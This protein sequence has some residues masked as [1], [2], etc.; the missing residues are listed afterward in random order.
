MPTFLKK[1]KI[2]HRIYLLSGIS[3]LFLLII[4][5]TGV[6]KMTVIGHELEEIAERDIP[7][8]E[9]L[10]KITVHQLEQAI[11][12]EQ[13]LRYSGV[14]AHDEAHTIESTVKH[15]KKLAHK[16]DEEI[17]QAEK[18][19]E[20]FIKESRDPA[21]IKE[22][23][24]VLEQLKTIE[25]HHKSYE[26]HAFAIFKRIGVGKS[27]HGSVAEA[28]HN[29]ATPGH[30]GG[31]AKAGPGGGKSLAAA[32][33]EVEGEQ[34]QLDKEIAALLHEME[35]F[36]AKSMN[37]ALADEQRGKWLILIMSGVI[38][39]MASVFS[40]LLGRTISKPVS[41]MTASIQEIADGNL[42]ADVPVSSFDDE[43]HEMSQAVEVFRQ[44]LKRV[45]QL[46]ADATVEREKRQHRQNELNQLTGIFGSTIG[47]VFNKISA[48][49]NLMVER[50]GS[51]SDQSGQ[52]KEMAQNVATE[53][54]ESS[55]NAQ[56]LSS[57]TEEM[58]ASVQEISNQVQ[59]SSEVA[60]KA[61]QSAEA[62]KKEVEALQ[63]IANEIG[64]VV[65]LITEIA[66]KTNLLALN[67]TIE[68][69][70]AGEAGKGFA[71]VASE[72][73][74]LA[75]QTSKA[76]EEIGDKITG[77]Q[78]ASRNSAVS[79]QEITKVIQEVD[80]FI[81]AIVAAAEQ[82]DA[83]TQEMARNVAFVADSATRVSENVNHISVQA[84]NVGQ[85]SQEVNGSAT[86]MAEDAGVLS[87]E[88]KTFL[89]A[90]QNT[91]VD[92]DTFESKNVNLQASGQINGSSWSGTVSEISAAHA[93][94]SPAMNYEPGEMVSLQI[95][96]IGSAL[97]A[98]IAIS[99]NGTTTLQ[100]P[101]DLSHLSHMRGE[102]QKVA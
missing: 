21:A 34:A 31:T 80:Q 66:E 99:E 52:T 38:L 91:D 2:G 64:Q 28:K 97:N 5:G 86:S 85:S 101:L 87:T 54:E 51:M 26:E 37:K 22:F 63:G 92:E 70:R 17:I 62:S 95:D 81:S 24:H 84:E 68:A 12:L 27:G 102:L 16:S 65:E 69:A 49:S 7:L 1:L 89:D 42:D 88:V 14:T 15:F 74:S 90:M 36:T 13:G 67:A 39:V 58:V 18:M 19:A 77:I 20:R 53:A 45:K 100:F 33:A 82:Q 6:Y 8:T 76:T 59:Q 75:S 98:R 83:T 96:G 94:V 3:L 32:V 61:V 11:L 30:G 43:I 44:D 23:K 55:A 40:F 4:G 57:A 78:S 10:S 29:G 71:V 25:K 72:V 60:K 56:S 73:K 50:S 93:V 35:R 79:I 46:E 41:K 9:L 47:A 48:A